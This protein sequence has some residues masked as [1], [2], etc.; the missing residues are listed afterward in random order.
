MEQEM[1]QQFTETN[2]KAIAS[3]VVGIISI[4]IPYIGFVLGIIGIVLAATAFKEIR[5]KNQ[6]GK[7]MAI[8]GLVCSIVSIA[9]YGFLIL[10]A[11][12]LINL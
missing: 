8:A 10:M 11:V 9:M 1:N 5:I 2:G 12:L 3:M 4:V 7:G 6:N